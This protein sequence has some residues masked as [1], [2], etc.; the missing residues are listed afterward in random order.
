MVD[1]GD[2]FL[3]LHPLHA[4]GLELEVSHGTGGILGQGLINS[5]GNFRAGNKLTGQQMR[6]KDFLRQIHQDVL[7]SKLYTEYREFHR[8]ILII[9][10]STLCVNRFAPKEHQKRKTVPIQTGKWDADA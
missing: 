6:G 8:N 9:S 7:L 4:H 3:C 1:V 2:G 5:N 10:K